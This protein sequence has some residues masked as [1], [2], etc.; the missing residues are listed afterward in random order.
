MRKRKRKLLT[1]LNEYCFGSADGERKR[2]CQ[3]KRIFWRVRPK[4]TKEQMMKEER[5]NYE[6]Q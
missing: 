4:M 6:S 5:E 2:N 1:L 3:M